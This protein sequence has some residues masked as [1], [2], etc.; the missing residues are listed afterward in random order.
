MTFNSPLIDRITWLG[1]G[2]F[3]ITGKSTI[4]INP[5]RITQAD[6]AADILILTDGAMASACAADIAK[7]RTPT[8]VVIGCTAVVERIP[9]CQVLRAWQ[10]LCSDR[11]AVKGVPTTPQGHVYQPE[12]DGIGV[13]VSIDYHDIYYAGATSAIPDGDLLHPDIALLPIDDETLGTVGA[14]QAARTLGPRWT[15]PY[16]WSETGRDSASTADARRFAGAV[17]S[18][19]S[20][21]L[22][23]VRAHGAMR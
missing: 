19:S 3:C 17:D 14:A 6:P 5:R 4:Y 11:V 20:V 21:L 15:I 7:L 1:G 22:L 23:K 18:P 12:R 13:V 10:T 8:T 9:D 2:G 16:N